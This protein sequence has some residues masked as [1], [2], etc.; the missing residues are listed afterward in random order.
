[1]G[2]G[3]E[4]EQADKPPARGKVRLN[5]VGMVK[6]ALN[7]M[8]RLRGGN[9][10]MSSGVRIEK[11]GKDARGFQLGKAAPV[12]RPEAADQGAGLKVSQNSIIFE[13][14]KGPRDLLTLRGDT[15]KLMRER[16]DRARLRTGAA[17]KD[18]YT[19]ITAMMQV[20][21]VLLARIMVRMAHP[22]Q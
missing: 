18:P 21:H 22:R 3:H 6:I 13:P 12:K 10:E 17:L 4:V 14:V 7:R 5:N 1:M 16:R 9:G 15:P 11:G 19:S 2:D 20:R 8:K